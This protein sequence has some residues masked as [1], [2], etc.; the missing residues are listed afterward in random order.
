MQTFRSAGTVGTDQ[1][2]HLVHP[3][4]EIK[5][6]PV[7]RGEAKSTPNQYPVAQHIAA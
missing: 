4:D 1:E 5:R 3:G 7:F 2:I 6:P